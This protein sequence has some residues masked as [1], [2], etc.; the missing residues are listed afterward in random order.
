LIPILEQNKIIYSEFNERTDAPTNLGI[1]TMITW[2][3]YRDIENLQKFYENV[4]G[5]EM[6]VDQGWTKIYQ[7]SSTGFIGLVD[8][9]KGMRSFSENKA[10]N[11]SFI[12]EDIDGWFH[13]VS[14]Q[15]SFEL[16][17]NNI[18]LEI[19]KKFSFFVGYDPGGYYLQFD[20]F[21]DHSSNKM[22]INYLRTDD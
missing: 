8:E 15:K 9:K 13:Y 3:Y 18:E 7:V 17:T 16:R 21:L 12:I 2:L 19:D 10:V 6:I 20:K 22:L 14:E 4:M 1:K 5:F 11:V